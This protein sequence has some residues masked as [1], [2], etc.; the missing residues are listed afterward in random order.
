MELYAGMVD[1]L[2]ENIGRLLHHLQSIDVLENTVV[3]FLSDNGPSGDDFY[4]HPAFRDFIQ[5]QYDNSYENMGSP[6][7]FVSYGAPWAEVSSVPFKGYKGHS[8]EGGILTPLIIS[9][10]GTRKSG[11]INHSFVTIQDIAPTL[12][13][14]AGI[15]AT[16]SSHGEYPPLGSA[17]TAGME[18]KASV[19]KPGYVF[20]VEHINKAFLIKD[21]WKIVSQKLPFREEQFELYN[22]K[23]DI[24]ESRDLK[25]EHPEIFA[26][27]LAEWDRF[28]KER[29]IQNPYPGDEDF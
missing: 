6:T 17:L 23:E 24:L 19:H 9:A 3:I 20:G 22:L 7:S 16:K 12:Y 1:N 8:T 4:H 15:D 26:E 14:I 25:N 5:S 11:S 13:E 29:K 21:G 28:V 27:M 18:L 10:P 2:D